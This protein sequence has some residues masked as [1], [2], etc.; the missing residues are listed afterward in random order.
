MIK[1][2]KNELINLS[3][4][5]STKYSFQKFDQNLM[6]MSKCRAEMNT[7]FKQTDFS[8]FHFFLKKKSYS[9]EFIDSDAII[10]RNTYSHI[11]KF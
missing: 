8:F 10:I 6:E 4:S 3:S 1:K 2:R 7:I 9:Q 5:C 11:H